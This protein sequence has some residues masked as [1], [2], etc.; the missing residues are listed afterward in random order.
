MKRI[1]PILMILVFISP[2][3]LL[4]QTG[5]Y[6]V[7]SGAQTDVNVYTD[8]TFINQTTGFVCGGW[9]SGGSVLLTTN[10]GLTWGPT[11]F[12][13]QALLNINFTNELTGYTI[14]AAFT[15]G[16]RFFKTTDG[17]LTWTQYTTNDGYSYYDSYYFNS[18]TGFLVGDQGR[19]IKTTNG[20]MNWTVC[21]VYYTDFLYT[22]DF[23]N[24]NTGFAA[25]QNGKIFIT[26]DGGGFWDPIF[27]SGSDIRSLKFLNQTTG[28]AV[29]NA[30]KLL[31]TTNSGINWQ[32][33]ILASGMDFTNIYLLS[34]NNMYIASENGVVLK[35]T[36][37]GLNWNQQVVSTNSNL[38][39]VYFLDEQFG[40]ACG[41]KSSVFRTQTGGELL[42]LTT[43]I[44]PL[45]NA[46]NLP[47]TPTLVWTALPDIINYTVQVSTNQNFNVIADSATLTTNQRNVPAGKLLS[48]TFYFWRVKSKNNLGTG[49]WTT[50]WRFMTGNVGV[51]KISSDVPNKYS[52]SPNFPNPFN[53]ITNIKFTLPKTSHVKINVVDITGKEIAI[54]VDGYLQSGTYKTDWDA[55]SFSSGIYFYKMVSE[56]Y[57]ETKK[58]ILIK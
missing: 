55:S 27:I 21:T 24:Q 48:N 26:T 46:F 18:N 33:Y 38:K 17:G 35:T 50:A 36:N 58:M 5:W 16:T 45:N 54:L 57:S 10:A 12:S 14:G 30:G 37:G 40:F 8:I 32:T 31:K 41:S 42:P 1:L 39:S 15:T 20:G 34:Q 11:L 7:Y 47:L 51:T 6:K 2:Y 29:G 52:I 43:L 3:Y 56:S 53:P 22:V 28:Y 25:G 9:Q 23:I 19:I 13:P 4:S 44:S 49:P